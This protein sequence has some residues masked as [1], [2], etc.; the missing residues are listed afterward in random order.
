MAWAMNRTSEGTMVCHKLG[1]EQP[2]RAG[3]SLDASP[4]GNLV[5]FA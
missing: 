2:D 1:H 3:K 5:E 4:E